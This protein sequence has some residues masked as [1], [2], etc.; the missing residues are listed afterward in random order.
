MNPV[1]RTAYYCTGVRALDARSRA[2]FCG[3]RYAERFMDDE[4]WRLF[5]PFRRFHAPNGSNV[6][7]HRMIDDLL[8]ARLAAHPHLRVVLALRT[9]LLDQGDEL[10]PRARRRPASEDLDEERFVVCNSCGRI[11]Y[12]PESTKRVSSDESE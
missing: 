7:R 6:V 12:L 8:R 1:S 10:L 11:L 3:D 4:A 9:R 2:P 5:A